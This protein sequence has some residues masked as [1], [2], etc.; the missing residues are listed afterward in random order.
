MTL[1]GLACRSIILE[2]GLKI[3]SSII[4][5]SSGMEDLSQ[6]FSS[7]SHFS[8]SHAYRSRH[9]Q[10]SC[11]GEKY[12]KCLGI[13]WSTVAYTNKEHFLTKNDIGDAITKIHE[14]RLIDLGTNKD[15]NTSTNGQD[16]LFK[17]PITGQYNSTNET[18]KVV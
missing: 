13:C 8:V 1:L 15:V 6:D 10:K 14:A 9:L 3:N 17:L 4:T 2:N 18:V 11:T 5:M 12:V 7:S 16:F